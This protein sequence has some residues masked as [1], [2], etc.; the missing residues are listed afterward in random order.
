MTP[1]WDRVGDA[2]EGVRTHEVKNVVT[3]NG[4]T[5]EVFRDDWG[6]AAAA[7]ASMI[8]VTLR[9]KAVS[10]WHMSSA[11]L[12]LQIAASRARLSWWRGRDEA[13]VTAADRAFCRAVAHAQCW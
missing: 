13:E 9:P 5:V 11:E 4:V 2:I 7:V 10:A 1:E 12:A 3:S 6:I 8:H